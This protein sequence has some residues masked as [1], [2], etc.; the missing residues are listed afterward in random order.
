M[1]EAVLACERVDCF[2]LGV[3][4][5]ISDIAQIALASDVDVVG[6]SFSSAFHRRLALEALTNLRIALPEPIAIWAGGE[7]VANVRRHIPGVRSRMNLLSAVEEAR[8]WQAALQSRAS[9]GARAP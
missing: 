9:D 1:T 6:L 4:T 8:R 5:P 3:Q 7:G 2:S